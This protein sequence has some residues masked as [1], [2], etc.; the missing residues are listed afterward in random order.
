MTSLCGQQ[1]TGIKDSLLLL[2]IL[3]L[4]SLNLNK[5]GTSQVGAISKAQKAQNIFLEKNLKFSKKK[6]SFGKCR[7]VPKNVKEGTLFDL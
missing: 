4:L 3:K 1:K 6:F 7:T 2:V 5:T